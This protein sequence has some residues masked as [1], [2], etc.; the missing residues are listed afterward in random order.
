MGEQR[1]IALNVNGVAREAYVEP[2]V[3]LVDF[4]RG[5]LGLGGV[6]VGCE[7]GVCGACTVLLEGTPIVSCMTLALDVQGREITTVE[8][9]GK[10]G[11]LDPIQEAFVSCDAYQCGYCTPGMLMTC[12]AFLD[13][14]ADPNP[15]QIRRAYQGNICRCAAYNHI[16]AA[17][18]AAAKKL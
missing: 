1:K 18:E 10:E 6:H 3:T 7:H 9:L 12:K 2:R 15:E 4:L 14:N 5:E 13:K 8:G 16:F 17:V 11:K